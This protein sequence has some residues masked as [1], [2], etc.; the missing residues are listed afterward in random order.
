MVSF[1]YALRAR[2]GSQVKIDGIEIVKAEWSSIES[3]K[4]LVAESWR[5]ALDMLNGKLR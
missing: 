5:S 2:P 3:S 1:R 4:K